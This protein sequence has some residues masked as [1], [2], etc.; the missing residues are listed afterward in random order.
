[1]DVLYAV[2]ASLDPGERRCSSTRPVEG[3]NF[4]WNVVANC[5][6]MRPASRSGAT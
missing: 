1:M 5:S 3:R 6:R 4:R 2:V